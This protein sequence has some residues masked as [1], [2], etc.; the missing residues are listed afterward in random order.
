MTLS[1]KHFKGIKNGQV[2]DENFLMAI[3][4]VG[5]FGLAVYEESSDYNEGYRS[6]AVLS[7]R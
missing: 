6:Y 5:A 3:A 7:D 1:K 4:T 2:F